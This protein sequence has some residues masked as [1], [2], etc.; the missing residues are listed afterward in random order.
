MGGGTRAD[1]EAARRPGER[2]DGRGWPRI[3]A[4]GVQVAHFVWVVWRGVDQL[5]G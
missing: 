1:G 4:C 2:Q 5:A 3:G